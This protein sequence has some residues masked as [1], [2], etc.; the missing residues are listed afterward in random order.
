MTGPQ[1]KTDDVRQGETGH[2]A[3]YVLGISTALAA[4]LLV[5]VAWTYFGPP[6]GGFGQGNGPQS[7]VQQEQNNPPYGMDKQDPNAQPLPGDNG[8]TAA[9]NVP[10]SG[11]TSAP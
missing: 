4:V 2:G 11:E 10:Q 1:K 8:Q 5:A 3:R 6:T 7:Q 9:P